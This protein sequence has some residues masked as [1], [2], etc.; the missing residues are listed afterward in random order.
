MATIQIKRK[1]SSGNGPLVGNG[2]IRA[3]EPLIDLNG[4]NLYISK[5]DK[6]G[7]TSSPLTASDYIEF[8]SKENADSAMDTKISVLDL[9]QAS[10]FNVGN[11]SGRI[12]VIDSDGKLSQNIIPQVAIT[13]TFV[14]SSAS[15]MLGLTS[16]QVGD[17]AVRTDLSK[18]FILKTADPSVEA[19]WQELMTPTDKVTSVNGKTGAVSIS[20]S[21]LGGVSEAVYNTHLNSSKHLTNQQLETLSHVY[22]TDPKCGSEFSYVN[23]C[24]SLSELKSTT[25]A[26]AL[27]MFV[28]IDGN[29]NPPIKKVYIGVNSSKVLTPSSTIDGGT[30]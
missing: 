25:V 12:P 19:N 23:Y 8:Y 9:G 20:L 10:R 15:A 21:E 5:A 26:G 18:T 24:E 17:V 16:A 2:T 14:V 1:T 30:Y 4:K 3:G 29:Y 27:S 13:D 22:V 7:T 28:S 11:T 6:T